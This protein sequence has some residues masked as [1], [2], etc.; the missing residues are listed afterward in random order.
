MANEQC[1]KAV[2]G[3]GYQQEIQKNQNLRKNWKIV[4]DRIA[5]LLGE[6]I[7]R[8]A[9][10][11][12]E[13]WLEMSE[14]KNEKTRALFTKQGK[15]KSNSKAAKELQAKYAEI[16]SEYGLSEYRDG[17]MSGLIHGIYRLAGETLERFTTAEGDIYFKANFDLSLGRTE[18]VS[19][20]SEIEYQEA[21]LAELKKT[22][23]TNADSNEA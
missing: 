11:P 22:E 2:R 13:L 20:I 9:L 12:K 1:F 14:I 5:E 21:Y 8:M 7:D 17:S 10:T 18:L 23:D 19:P 4:R 15:L 3:T 16:I 6:D